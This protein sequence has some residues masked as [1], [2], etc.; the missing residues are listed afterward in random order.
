M[1]IPFLSK[2]HIRVVPPQFSPGLRN[3]SEAAF[4]PYHMPSCKSADIQFS[5]REK[6]RMINSQCLKTKKLHKKKPKQS[7]KTMGN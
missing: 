6:E 1:Y 2:F 7:L 4:L 5:G 3:F